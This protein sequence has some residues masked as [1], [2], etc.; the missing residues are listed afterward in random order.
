MGTEIERKFLVQGDGWRG[1]SGVLYRQGYI[2]TQNQATVRVRQ[3]GDKGYLTIKGPTA[4]LSR[5]EYEYKIPLAEAEAMLATLC[6]APLVE[7]YRYRIP[8]GELVWEV[9]EFLGDNAGLILA[10][11]ELSHPDTPVELPD[12]VSEEVSHDPRY[13]NANL[14]QHPYRHWPTIS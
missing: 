1:S 9:D 7:K 11:V 6:A 10:E 12:W 4:N 8:I 5:A 13:F 2:P 14:A 3:A